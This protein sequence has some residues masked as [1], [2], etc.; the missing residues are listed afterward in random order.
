VDPSLIPPS[1]FPLRIGDVKDF[2]SL[3]TASQVEGV[4]IFDVSAG[5]DTQREEAS[6]AFESLATAIIKRTSEGKEGK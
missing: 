3:A 5:T 6:D 1:A 4:P 2:A